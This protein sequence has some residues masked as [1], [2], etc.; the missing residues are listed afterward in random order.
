M[1]SNLIVNPII[2]GYGETVNNL[3]NVTNA[4]VRFNVVNDGNIVSMTL[5]DS[6]VGI[7]IDSTGMVAGIL[8]TVTLFITQDSTGNRIIDWTGLAPY[9]PTS[10]NIPV[11]GP[12][13]STTA[14]YTDVIV[15]YTLNAGT[16]WRGVLTLK[17]YAG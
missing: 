3:G 2:K 9:W 11:S 4:G 6:P 15:L 14:G 12:V 16:S 10:E 7:T 13:L 8:Y 1:N 5:T 17:G